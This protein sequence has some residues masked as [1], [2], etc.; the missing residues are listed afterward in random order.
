MAGSCGFSF[1]KQKS[2]TVKLIPDSKKAVLAQKRVL[3]P[4]QDIIA[5]RTADESAKAHKRALES[6]SK[7]RLKRLQSLEK[8]P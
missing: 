1:K 8:E 7:E 3:E 2:D 5:R 4:P 6:S